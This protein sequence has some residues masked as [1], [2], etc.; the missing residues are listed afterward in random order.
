MCMC[1]YRQDD[2]ERFLLTSSCNRLKV[3]NR[4]GS[5]QFSTRWQ[6]RLLRLDAS[7]GIAVS[8]FL[9]SEKPLYYFV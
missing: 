7:T 8:S 2:I 4:K 6:V 1:F 5:S 3:G 9:H